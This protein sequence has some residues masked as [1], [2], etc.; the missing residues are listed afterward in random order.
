[1]KSM[2]LA[3]ILAANIYPL[4]GKVVELNTIEDTVTFETE[5]G[6]LYGFYGVE[7][8]MIGDHVA[9]IMYDNETP[10]DV[11]DDEILTVRY[12]GYDN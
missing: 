4:S 3:L 10:N 2:I 11:T 8:W 6:M 5:S 9:A 7:D 1:M 12:T